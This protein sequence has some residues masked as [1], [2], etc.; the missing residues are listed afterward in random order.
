MIARAAVALLAVVAVIVGVPVIFLR[1]GGQIEHGN[2]AFDISPDGEHIVFSAA[3][4]DLYSLHLKTLHVLRLTKTD[5]TETTP[6]FSPD[7]RSIAYAADVQGSKE[8]LIFV[9][10]MDGKQ[11]QQLTNNPDASDFMPSYSPDGSQIVFARAHLHRPYS[12][13]GWTWDDWDAYVIKSDGTQCGAS[14]TKRLVA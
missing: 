13:G 14:R 7:G 3:D 6:T 11:V 9:R 10:S 8:R 2:V 5:A 12:M 4:G 1:A